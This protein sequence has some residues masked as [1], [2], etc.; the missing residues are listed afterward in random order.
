M[1]SM[2]ESEF[3]SWLA[4]QS[5]AIDQS[6]ESD[7][8]SHVSREAELHDFISADCRRRGW[9]AFHGSMSKPTHRTGGE[10][11]FVILADSGRVL[12]VECKTRTGKLSPE[13]LAIKV[14]AETLGHVVHVVRSER[15][16]MEV[17]K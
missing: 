2:S 12:L 14:Q 13:Q 5:K 11:D 15:E 6:I 8:E 17:A 1:V 16:W 3:Q 9:I 4:R 10:P 7:R